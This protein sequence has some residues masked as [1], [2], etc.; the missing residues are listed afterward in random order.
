MKKQ[1]N[2][3]QIDE[4]PNDKLDELVKKRKEE[5]SLIKNKKD[6]VADLINKAH[7]KECK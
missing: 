3:V 6:I 2:T 4:Q 5:G 7:T 1:V